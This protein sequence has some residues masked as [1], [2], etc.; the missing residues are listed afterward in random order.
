VL[1]V[2]AAE[3]IADRIQVAFS[4]PLQ[5][6]LRL[7]KRVIVMPDA[8]EAGK[9]YR[10]TVVESLAKRGIE[11]RVVTFEDAGCK[12]LSE[13]TATHSTSE[14]AER[15]G[16]DWVPAPDPLSDEEIKL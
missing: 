3:R 14:V 8:D 7:C 13:F 6:G 2:S 16:T 4:N 10:D 9:R 15:A 5:I 11:Y 1:G 12:D